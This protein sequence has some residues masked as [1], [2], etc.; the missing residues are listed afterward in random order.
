MSRN[1]MV[2]VIAAHLTSAVVSAQELAPARQSVVVDS[3]SMI[4]AASHSGKTLY[5]YSA[6]TGSWAGV[7]LSNPDKSPVGP[8][9]IG[10]SVGYVMVGKK[11]HAFSAKLGRWD[12]IEL[13][14]VA[15]PMIA[16]DRVRIDIGSKLF[17][18]SG[19]T[20]KWATI[21]LAEDIKPGFN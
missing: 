8:P 21:D 7:V 12:V 3:V 16:G 11:V 13:P 4:I 2:F 1:L 10:P 14:E 5:G 18:Y 15:T 17:M 19:S 6:F 9:T 20:G